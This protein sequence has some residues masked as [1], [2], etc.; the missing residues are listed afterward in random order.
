[1]VDND[2]S[3]DK[4]LKKPKIRV[5]LRSWKLAY[6]LPK[7]SLMWILTDYHAQIFFSVSS[8]KKSTSVY[9]W[10]DVYFSKF[11]WGSFPEGLETTYNSW[12]VAQALKCKLQGIYSDY[13]S[14]AELS[15]I[16]DWR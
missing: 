10:T 5:T 3:R 4:F 16:L 2:W 6:M 8:K 14:I 1:M 12:L 7:C 11:R 13:S 15:Q 9:E